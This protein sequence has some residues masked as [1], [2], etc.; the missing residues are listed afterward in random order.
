[1]KKEQEKKYY[2]GTNIEIDPT[3]FYKNYN[4]GVIIPEKEY[5]EMLKRE[6][7][8]YGLTIDEL[9]AEEDQFYMVDEDGND[10]YHSK[11]IEG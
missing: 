10:Y 11:Y 8:E 1:M 5:V 4:T 6:S 7:K 3:V 9:I 2:E